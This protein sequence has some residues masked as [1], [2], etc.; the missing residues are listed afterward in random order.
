MK[1]TN[2]TFCLT[3]C[4]GLA[5]AGALFTTGCAGNRYDRST[6][7]YID[8]KSV[9]SRVKDALHDNAEYKFDGVQVA[10][11]KGTVQLSGFVDSE[12]QKYNASKI[13]KTVQGVRDVENNITVGSGGTR[14]TGEYI[15]DKSLSS[16]VNH[17]LNENQT[18]KFDQVSVTSMKGTVQLSG[19]V[20]TADQK[21]QAGDITKNVPGVQDVVNNITVKDSLSQ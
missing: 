4:L 1:I 3:L 9:D 18:Y 12:A 5:A 7:E 19:F 2:H 6:G 14:S 8:D 16:R 20:N 10:C 21:S 13:A 17:A 15:D 11:F